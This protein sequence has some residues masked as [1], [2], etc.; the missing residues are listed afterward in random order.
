MASADRAEAATAKRGQ[1]AP[2]HASG[3]Q[4]RRSRPGG[5]RFWRF[6]RFSL[7]EAGK[8]AAADDRI[9]PASA[10][11]CR[12][13]G[14]VIGTDAAVHA[15]ATSPGCGHGV[16]R[17]AE[18]IDQMRLRVRQRS[19]VR[20]CALRKSSAGIVIDCAQ[21]SW[22]RSAGTISWENSDNPHLILRAEGRNICS[23]SP[24]EDR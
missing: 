20:A 3:H 2:C 15:M 13:G 8:S 17:C 7:A 24:A 6:L 16:W 11:A 22:S 23:R 19:E 4:R 5:E 9:E 10:T 14:P 12:D 21:A 18:H 1:G